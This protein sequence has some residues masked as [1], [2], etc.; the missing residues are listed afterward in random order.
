MHVDVV[1][2]V[3]ADAEAD[4]SPSLKRSLVTSSGVSS[5]GSGFVGVGSGVSVAV[6]SGAAVSVAVGVALRRR[7]GGGLLLV[8]PAPAMTDHRDDRR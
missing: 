5:G 6:A 2:H 8:A 4:V 1:G 3:G 7:V